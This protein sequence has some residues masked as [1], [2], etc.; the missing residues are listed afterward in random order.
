MKERKID[1]FK[2]KNN[3]LN[4]LQ[5]KYYVDESYKFGHH[6]REIKSIIYRNDSIHNSKN[7]NN[8]PTKLSKGK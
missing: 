3:Q 4:Q 1:K 5:D 6:N 2:S 7:D 8:I